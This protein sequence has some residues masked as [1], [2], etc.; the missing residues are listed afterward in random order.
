MSAPKVPTRN[1]RLASAGSSDRP[2]SEPL[3][4]VVVNDVKQN[5]K[6]PRPAIGAD[7]KTMKRLPG[8]QVG[9]LKQVLGVCSV[10]DHSNRRSVKVVEM[11]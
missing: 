3:A 5:P 2:G 10:A 9:L 1:Y 11:R 4:T 8:L 6:E 7:L